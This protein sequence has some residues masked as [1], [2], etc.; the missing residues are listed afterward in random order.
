M[1]PRNPN[2]IQTDQTSYIQKPICKRIQLLQ[3]TEKTCKDAKI[4]IFL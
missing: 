2:L 4:I 3:N 1:G